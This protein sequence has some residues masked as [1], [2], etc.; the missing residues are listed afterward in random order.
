MGTATA[1]G[2]STIDFGPPGSA[3]ANAVGY[4][5]PSGD[6][7]RC[8]AAPQV[9]QR[10]D[11]FGARTINKVPDL[12]ITKSLVGEPLPGG[13][14]LLSLDMTSTVPGQATAF[15]D[16]LPAALVYDDT[17]TGRRMNGSDVCSPSSPSI[18]VL[19]A[20]VVPPVIYSLLPTCRRTRP[21]SRRSTSP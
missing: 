14:A 4:P 21:V 2:L 11:R 10:L 1:S 15:G 9:E 19:C 5:L 8:G 17:A 12:G 6:V 18:D 20:P 16:D 13:Q 3:N 7:A